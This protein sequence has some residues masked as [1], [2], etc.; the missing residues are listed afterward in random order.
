[1]GDYRTSS[2]RFYFFIACIGIALLVLIGAL[3]VSRLTGV[4]AH[5]FTVD[6]AVLSNIHPLM[7]AISNLGILLWATTVAVC[8]FTATVLQKHHPEAPQRTFLLCFGLFTSVLMIDDLFMI[9]EEIAPRYLF[10]DEVYVLGMYG[11]L[12]GG[13]IVYFGRVILSTPYAYL[14]T[15]LLFFGGSIVIDLVWDVW[16]EWPVFL[17]DSAKFLGIV[18]WLGYFSIICYAALSTP[19]RSS[20]PSVRVPS[21]PHSHPS[22]R[23][24]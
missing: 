14:L 23:R 20:V 6:P 2:R 13:G 4:P 16:S 19:R 7:G 22:T 21:R 12:L 3:L 8:L 9:H 17:E 15:A 24:E 1:M 10:V 5:W 11:L 18:S